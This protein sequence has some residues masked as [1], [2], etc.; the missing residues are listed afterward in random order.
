MSDVSRDRFR[1]VAP[2][3]KSTNGTRELKANSTALKPKKGR[4]ACNKA[5]LKIGTWKAAA[6]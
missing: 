4:I 3:H 1:I 5:P 2:P 6:C